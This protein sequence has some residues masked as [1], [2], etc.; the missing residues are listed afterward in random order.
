MGLAGASKPFPNREHAVRHVGNVKIL[1]LIKKCKKI[2]RNHENFSGRQQVMI[3]LHADIFMLHLCASIK[4]Q[5]CAIYAIVHYRL[6]NCIKNM[7]TYYYTNNYKIYSYIGMGFVLL[8]R[9]NLE[10]L[11]HGNGL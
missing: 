11:E 3:P 9:Y 1:H 2:C 8:L 6:N 5:L 7:I 4:M 10:F